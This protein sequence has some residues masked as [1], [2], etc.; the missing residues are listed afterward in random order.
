LLDLLDLLG[1]NFE[2]WAECGVHR[3]LQ[4]AAEL[5][6]GAVPPIQPDRCIKHALKA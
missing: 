5:S 2:E 4:K 1:I 3:R 6:L